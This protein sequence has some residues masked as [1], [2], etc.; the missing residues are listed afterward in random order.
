MHESLTAGIA[1]A[2]FRG[3]RAFVAR[4]KDQY[5]LISYRLELPHDTIP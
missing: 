5:N 4:K 1:H 3:L 2:G